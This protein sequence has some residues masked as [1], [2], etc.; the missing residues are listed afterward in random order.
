VTAITVL[1]RSDGSDLPLSRLKH[2][3]IETH[4]PAPATLEHFPGYKI[5]REGKVPFPWDTP[6]THSDARL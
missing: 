4:P 3:V 6:A 5:H 1:S 2:Q